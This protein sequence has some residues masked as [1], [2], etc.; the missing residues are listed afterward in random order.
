MISHPTKSKKPTL[1]ELVFSALS[2]LQVHRYNP[3]SIRRNQTVW[4]KLIA[5]AE[6][7][8][9]KGKLREQ[10]ILDFLA[11]HKIDSQL[12]TQSCRGWKKHAEYG[13]K[14]L[15]Q[16]HRFGYFERSNLQAAQH[17]IPRAMRKSLE[18]YKNYC[19]KERHLSP[20]TVNEYVRQTS[21]ILDFL[22]K[23]GVKSF[24]EI[25]PEDLSDYVYSLS[26]Y[27]QKTVASSVSCMRLYF[28][29]LFYKR[30]LSQDLSGSVPSVCF[31]QRA[32]IPS[33]WDKT[34]LKQLLDRVDRCSPRGKRDY[35]I[36]LLACRLGI[37]S[38][39][40]RTLTLDNI[41]WVEETITF[42]QDKTGRS[43][44]LPLTDEV[45]CA[46]IDYIRSARPQTPYREVFLCLKPPIRPFRE[47]G[48]LSHIIQYWQE[49]AGI[50]FKHPQRHGLHSLRH[51]LATYLLED[52]VPFAVI[53]DI[54]GHA[55]M[56]STM[57]YAKA[58]VESLRGVAL[59]VQEVRH[60]NEA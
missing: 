8:G 35:A 48:H 2:Q 58:G 60:V 38:G 9:Y 43:L 34:L 59:P 6:Q 5:F 23:R 15:W 19:E 56:T 55:S 40:I 46:L 37:R 16:Y 3:R 21:A 36:L 26:H 29:F 32:T 51:S 53:A 44:R 7:Q 27:R 33:V 25:G 47:N 20:H 10:L 39:D 42:I 24:S 49:L 12:P 45:G 30:H 14:L 1:D 31:P 18:D 4:R 57:I 50:Q 41:D 28:R 17:R 13:L 11:H 54:L 52:D 22:G